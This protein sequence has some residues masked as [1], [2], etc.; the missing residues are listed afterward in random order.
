MLKLLP[1]QPLVCQLERLDR[2]VV[3][4]LKSGYVMAARRSASTALAR[5]ITAGRAHHVSSADDSR[6]CQ[7]A[8]APREAGDLIAL[9]RPHMQRLA[10]ELVLLGPL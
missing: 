4:S 10:S 2:F 5:G 6:E 9:D 8:A 1:G 7:P 3:R